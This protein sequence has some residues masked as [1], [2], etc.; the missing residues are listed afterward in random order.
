MEFE[1]HLYGERREAV[2][3]L[4]PQVRHP[5]PFTFFER[6]KQINDC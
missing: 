4:N 6:S 3:G 1:I 2:R 5:N